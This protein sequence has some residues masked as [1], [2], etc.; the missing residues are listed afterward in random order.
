M[1]VQYSKFSIIQEWAFLYVCIAS[2]LKNKK[3]MIMVVVVMII[4]II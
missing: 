1:E 4:I 2:V 3:I